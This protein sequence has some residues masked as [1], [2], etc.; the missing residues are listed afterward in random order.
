MLDLGQKSLSVRALRW[1]CWQLSRLFF[2]IEIIGSAN[3]PPEGPLLIAPNHQ[4]YLDPIFIGLAITRR[5][6]WMAWH[7]L[8]QVPLLARLIRWCG[9]FPVDIDRPDRQA[10]RLALDLLEAGEALVVFPEGGRSPDG[11]VGPFKAGVARL[12]LSSGAEI[13][14]VTISGGDRVWPPGRRLPRPGKIRVT[15]HPPL[16][17]RKPH[18]R[19]PD[20]R[21][22]AA[23]LA[24]ELRLT[25]SKELEV[26]S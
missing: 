26:R 11:K 24:E 20:W 18:A 17:G 9:A 10:F 5:V 7:K 12:A 6:R 16:P 19:A 15:I 4:T 13:V 14:P 8:F 23:A 1:F 25:I 2:R 22:Q 3:I 21:A